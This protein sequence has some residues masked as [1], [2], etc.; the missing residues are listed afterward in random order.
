MRLMRKLIAVLA[1]AALAVALVAVPAQAGKKKKVHETFGANLLPFPN[2]SSAT[3][4]EKPGCSGGIEGVHWT[5]VEFTSPGKG[6]LRFWMEGFSGDHDIYLFVDGTVMRGDQAQVP[7]GAPPE[8]EINFPLIKGQK[9]QLVAC[10]WFGEPEVL[11]HF[12]GTF[13]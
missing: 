6:N 1:V 9:V 8:E 2:L 13:K 4:T 10:N 5:S 11:A 12:E 7:D 3:G